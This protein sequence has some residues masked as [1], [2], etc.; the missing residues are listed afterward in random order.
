MNVDDKRIEHG[1]IMG[2]SNRKYE[3]K[4][5]FCGKEEHYAKGY[6]KN[7]FARYLRRGTAEYK[8][9]KGR[10]TIPLNENQINKALVLVTASR[11]D[12]YK[13]K[14]LC[15]ETF[16]NW[17]KGNSKPTY[18]KLKKIFDFLNLDIVKELEIEEKY[19]GRRKRSI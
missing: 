13:N 5:I 9:P 10:K 4:C 19:L 3:K 17:I 7:C 16:N 2:L 6:C 15:N 18:N 8:I 11:F 14:L 1:R 12:L